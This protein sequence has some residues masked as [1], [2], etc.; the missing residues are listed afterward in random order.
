MME[1]YGPF[2]LNPDPHH[3]IL[4]KTKLR[5]L[6]V[7]EHPIVLTQAPPTKPSVDPTRCSPVLTV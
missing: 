3:S 1:V 6:P 7:V 5:H 4:E 2:R